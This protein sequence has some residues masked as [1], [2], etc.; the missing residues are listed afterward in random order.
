MAGSETDRF[1]RKIPQNAILPFKVIEGHR[2]W[3]FGT[4]RKLIYDLLSVNHT[5][6]TYIV[7]CTVFEIAQIINQI[8]LTDGRTDGHAK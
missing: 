6:L 5:N 2:F 7:S 3:Y 4:D 1:R 8:G